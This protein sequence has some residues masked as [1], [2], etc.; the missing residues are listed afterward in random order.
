LDETAFSA[1]MTGLPA[2]WTKF[3]PRGILDVRYP[4]LTLP[5]G[6][7]VLPG[8]DIIVTYDYYDEVTGQAATAQERQQVPLNFGASYASPVLADRTLHIGTEGYLPTGMRGLPDVL[9]APDPN[10]PGARARA[11]CRCSTTQSRRRRTGLWPRRPSRKP[12]CMPS[13]A[14]PWSTARQRLMRAD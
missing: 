10:N 13:R 14:P 2:A 5:G 3:L 12:T 11:C 7:P 9:W 8:C 1:Q 6:E 4:Y